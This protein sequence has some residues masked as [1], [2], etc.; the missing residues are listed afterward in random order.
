[1]KLVVC[2]VFDT[3]SGVFG[4]P[5]FVPTVGVAARAFTDEVNRQ[6][7]DNQFYK[8]PNDFQLFEIGSFDDN[9]GVLE[10]LVPAR[11]VLAGGVATV[12]EGR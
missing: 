1:M 2:S 3:V 11:L 9:A 10:S 12:S 8:H 4:Q 7:Q 5:M 6:A